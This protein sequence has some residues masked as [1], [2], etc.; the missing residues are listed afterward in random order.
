MVR[1]RHKRAQQVGIY[2]GEI[3][4]SSI[5]EMSRIRNIRWIDLRRRQTLEPSPTRTQAMKGNKV[6]AV[7]SRLVRWHQL[8]RE[9]ACLRRISDATLKDLGLS[10]ADVE[11]ESHRHFWEDPFNK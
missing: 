11:I 2:A 10:R 5:S 9:R 4:H 7:W 8:A 1:N 6:S 3:S